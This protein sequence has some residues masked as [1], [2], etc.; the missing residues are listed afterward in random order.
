MYSLNSIILVIFNNE[1]FAPRICI[2][3]DFSCCFT[4]ITDGIVLIVFSVFCTL[5]DLCTTR[6][7][8]LL[9]LEFNFSAVHP[10]LIVF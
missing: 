3:L 9:L 5:R 6:R 8:G 2:S 10:I 4:G 1:G 7:Y